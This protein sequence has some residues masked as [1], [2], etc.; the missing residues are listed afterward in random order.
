MR[1]AAPG[2]VETPAVE[3]VE[4][5]LRDVPRPGVG[6][7]KP[8]FNLRDKEEQPSW[9]EATTFSGQVKGPTCLG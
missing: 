9:Y 1:R 3:A 8:T 6:S 2:E 7:G 4:E 5:R